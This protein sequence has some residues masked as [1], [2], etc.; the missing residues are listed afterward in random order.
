MEYL[1]HQI[2]QE[3]FHPTKEKVC[4]IV[5]APAP[6]NV[7]QL[8]FFLGMLNYYS[9]PWHWYCILWDD[10]IVRCHVDHIHIRPHSADLPDKSGYF[11][12][13]YNL[14]HIKISEL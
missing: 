13:K 8:K 2:S 7:T 11:K 4:A 10:R 3:G 6:Y 5:D 9:N 1:S 12:H 14:L